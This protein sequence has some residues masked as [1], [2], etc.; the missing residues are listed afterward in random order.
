MSLDGSPRHA[1][2]ALR[3]PHAQAAIF[4]TLITIFSD[5]RMFSD[6]LADILRGDDSIAVVPPVTDNAFLAQI[7]VVDARSGRAPQHLWPATE[8]LVIFVGAADD[9]AWALDALDLGARGILTRSAPR[10]D[11]LK[12]IGIVRQGGI[13]ARRRW[14]SSKVQ[15]DVGR[16][17]GSAAPVLRLPAGARLSPREEE[18]FHH[19]ASGMATKQLAL[20][21][22]I[23][24]ATVKV[25]LTR[26][27]QKLG[28]GGR[29]ELAALY[30]GLRKQPSSNRSL[31]H[32]LDR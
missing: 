18:V 3:A 9:D 19:A 26:I 15:R 23:S 32:V 28:V 24:E 17:A 12:A 22:A 14:L 11:L 10:E 2:D 31:S 7:A 13:W 4:P 5:D 20:R 6:A 29:A 21:L 30:Y 27:Y 1:H 8:A 25:H 16:A